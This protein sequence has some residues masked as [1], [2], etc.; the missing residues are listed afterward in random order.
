[1]GNLRKRKRK[2]KGKTTTGN[3]R[4]GIWHFSPKKNFL[5]VE[6]RPEND[7]GI[8]VEGKRS[9]DQNEVKISGLF[10]PG[11]EKERNTD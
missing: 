7:G 3:A 4:W 11:T 2:E 5:T 8:G 1:L 9:G 10:F 6:C